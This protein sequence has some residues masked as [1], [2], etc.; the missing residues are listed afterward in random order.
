MLYRHAGKCAGSTVQRRETVM[1]FHRRGALTLVGGAL[2]LPLTARA[3]TPQPAQLRNLATILTEDDRFDEFERLLQQTGTMARLADQ[4]RQ[5]TVFAPTDAAFNMLPA[6]FLQSLRVPTSDAGQGGQRTGAVVLAHISEGAARPS[7]SLAR[8]TLEL[9]A[10]NGGRIKVDGSQNP[11]QISSITGPGVYGAPG[12]N[13]E[14]TIKVITADIMA[15][16]GVIH[17]IDG[18]LRP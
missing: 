17:V 3:Q 18:L 11:I 10:M 4:S 8:Q 5:Y 2:V 15:S 1:S 7:S 16:N 13:A 9:P 14:G 12:A 6:N